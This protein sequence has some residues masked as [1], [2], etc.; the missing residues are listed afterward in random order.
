MGQKIFMSIN[1]NWNGSGNI[2]S[3]PTLYKHK[4]QHRISFMAKYLVMEYDNHIYNCFS[5]TAVAIAEFME[6]DDALKKPISANE[7]T[8]QDIE[9]NIFSWAVFSPDISSAFISCRKVNFYNLI[10]S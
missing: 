7:S 6:W 4:A 10:I 8:C 2:L 9:S 5:N 3:F 1:C